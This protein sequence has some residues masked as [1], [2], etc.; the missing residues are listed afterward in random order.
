MSLTPI[1]LEQFVAGLFDAPERWQHAVRHA[2]DMRVYQQIWDDDD[3]NAWLICWSVDQDTGFHDHDES[4]AAIAVISGQVREDRLRLGRAPRSRVLGP[5]SIFTVPAVA[6]HRVLHAG[7]AP[8]VTLHAYSPPLIR[9]GAYRIGADGEL[10]RE[11]R[12]AEE[13]LRPTPAP[14]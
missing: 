14:S 7:T 4:A 13:E 1:E 8:A 5:G 2:S 9:T 12:S 10:E 3:V 11:L 6:I